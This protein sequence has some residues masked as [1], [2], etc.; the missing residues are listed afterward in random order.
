MSCI[1]GLATVA[2]VTR[3]AVVAAATSAGAAARGDGEGSAMINAMTAPPGDRHR[4]RNAMEH[5]L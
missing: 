4:D 2:T 3:L 5:L 1:C